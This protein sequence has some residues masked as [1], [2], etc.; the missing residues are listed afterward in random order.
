[1]PLS[2]GTAL[3]SYA[4]TAKVGDGGTRHVYQATD[5]K[6]NRQWRSGSRSLVPV[7]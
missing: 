3:G 2:P 5:A 6:L 4:V 7:G 1:M